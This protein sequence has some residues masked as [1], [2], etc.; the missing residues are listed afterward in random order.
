MSEANPP[1]FNESNQPE[2]RENDLEDT[3]MVSS[4]QTPILAIRSNS[5]TFNLDTIKKEL[6]ELELEFLVSIANIHLRE[7][8]TFR[9]FS[10]EDM[11]KAMEIKSL[12]E[13][14]PLGDIKTETEEK[15]VYAI[16]YPTKFGQEEFLQSLTRITKEGVR[17]LVIPKPKIKNGRVTATIVT[18]SKD[19]AEKL[20][21]K[22]INIFPNEQ[23][24]FFSKDI[25]P[26]SHAVFAHG[27]SSKSEA[28]LWFLLKSLSLE[29]LISSIQINPGMEKRKQAIVRFNQVHDLTKS[30]KI[31]WSDLKSRPCVSCNFLPPTHSSGCKYNE[32]VKLA[33]KESKPPTTSGKPEVKAKQ[34]AILP[35]KRYMHNTSY[36][37]KINKQ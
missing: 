16:G 26:K 10:K 2:N 34:K 32:N 28:E 36:K 12:V 9:F 30:D 6:D 17:N 37:P 11:Q 29:I 33:F 3:E 21:K 15:T 5:K 18:F 20:I 7:Y 22:K 8:T 27:F 19:H 13:A 14:L 31:Q 24:C 35:T 1:P 23:L 4:E 25:A